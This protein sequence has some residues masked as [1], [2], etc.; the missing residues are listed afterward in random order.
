L[1]VQNVDPTPA[2]ER[3]VARNRSVEL[4][5]SLIIL[6]LAATLGYDSWR[7]GSSWEEGIGPQSGYFPFY[8]SLIMGIAAL[9]G[10]VTA[11]MESGRES[12]TFVTRDQIGR[13][14]KVLVPIFIFCLA[15]QFIGIYVSSFL[16]TTGF[17]WIVGRISPVVALAT[18]LIFSLLMFGV[19]EVAFNVILPKGPLEAALGY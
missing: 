5:V 7:T 11:L 2:D 1:S 19:F 15:T 18:G 17:M 6:A 8:L 9:Y 16:L 14:L 4:I 13:V 3:P 10:F 12:G